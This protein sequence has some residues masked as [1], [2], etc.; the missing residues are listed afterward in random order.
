MPD[1]LSHHPAMLIIKPDSMP[2]FWWLVPWAYARTLHRN[3]VAL[4]ALCDR[5]DDLLRGAYKPRARWKIVPHIHEGVTR[6]YFQDTESDIYGYADA[7]PLRGKCFLYDGPS[8]SFVSETDPAKAID[9]CDTLN[10][11]K[12][13]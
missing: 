4:K 8:K 11:G 7:I 13:L 5:Q 1:P 9:Y 10:G 2:R 6:Y 3:C 12:N